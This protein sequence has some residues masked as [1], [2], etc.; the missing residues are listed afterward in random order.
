MKLKFVAFGLSSTVLIC[1][2]MS[3]NRS[4][5]LVSLAETDTELIVFSDYPKSEASKVE[6]YLDSTFKSKGSLSKNLAGPLRLSTGEEVTLKAADG[7]VE[8]I[9]AKKSSTPEGYAEVKKIKEN[10]AKKLIR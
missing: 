6:A 5:T 8:I 1:S 10:L 9:Y 4:T 7:H 2:C 3:F